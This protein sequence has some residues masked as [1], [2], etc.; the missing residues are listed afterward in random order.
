[1]RTITMNYEEYLLDLRNAQLKGCDRGWEN[2]YSA[3]EK[4]TSREELLKAVNA[5][6]IESINKWHDEND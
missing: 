4:T 5:M 6:K 3:L 2:C 1:M